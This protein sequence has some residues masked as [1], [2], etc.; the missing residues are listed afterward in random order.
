MTFEK[1]EKNNYEVIQLHVMPLALKI[2]SRSLDIDV[3][4]GGGSGLRVT[5]LY[6]VKVYI[7]YK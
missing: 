1:L 4:K 5:K 3:Y 7:Y 6:K 2:C